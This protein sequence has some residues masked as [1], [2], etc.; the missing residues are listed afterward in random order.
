[1]Q[2]G[3]KGRHLTAKRA[4]MTMY[5]IDRSRFEIHTLYSYHNVLLHSVTTRTPISQLPE[6]GNIRKFQQNY[7]K[8][9]KIL[10]GQMKI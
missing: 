9:M 6:C 10:I 3:K 1:M 4:Q 8:A 5:D 2:R 7:H